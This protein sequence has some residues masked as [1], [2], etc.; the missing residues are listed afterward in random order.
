VNGAIGAFGVYVDGVLA[1]ASTGTNPVTDNIYT[2]SGFMIFDI[3][4]G[5]KIRNLK[6]NNELVNLSK[7][8]VDSGSYKVSGDKENNFVLLERPLIQQASSRSILRYTK[9]GKM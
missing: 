2:D 1:T 8:Q 5:D 7:F 6:F 4:A 9:T 3:D